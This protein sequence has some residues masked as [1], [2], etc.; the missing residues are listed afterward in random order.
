VHSP[1][2]AAP[3]SGTNREIDVLLSSVRVTLGTGSIEDARSRMAPD[4]D[5]PRLVRAALEHG[6]MPHL[7]LAAKQIGAPAVPPEILEQLRERFQANARLNLSRAGELLRVLALFEAHGISAVPLKGPV[8]AMLL[9][10]TLAMRQFTDL[11]LLVPTGQL[12]RAEELLGTLG[13]DVREAGETSVTATW[14]GDQG[15]IDVDLHWALADHRYSFPLTQDA[16]RRRMQRVPFMHTTVSQPA[17]DDQLILLISHPAKHC[18]SR[19]GWLADVAAFIRANQ[20]HLD[21][22][23]LLRHATALR[24]RRLLL[25]G[26][27]LTGALLWSPVPRDVAD[28]AA[29]DMAVTRLVPDLCSRMLVTPG[30]T[31]RHTGSY[32]LVD[33]GLLYVRSREH[34]ADKVPYLLYLVRLCCQ[35]WSITPNERDR[36]V[37]A[38][39]QSL[40]FLYVAIRP[41]RLL[42]TYGPRLMR[43]TLQAAAS[44]R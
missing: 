8:L 6:V 26:L 43:Y 7:H 9:H 34:V 15:R 42:C 2:V 31:P 41:F 16:V 40:A 36:A 12:T 4:L 18:W 17:V 33:A 35:W 11:D 20:T 32:G 30:D 22:D 3:V 28:R 27:H 21:W 23:E 19:L 10:G 5:W 1:T 37:V 39:P 44:L 13:Y 29:A 24:G 38:L 25:L 14:V